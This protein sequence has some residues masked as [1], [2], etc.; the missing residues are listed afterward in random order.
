MIVCSDFYSHPVWLLNGLF[1]E[2]HGQSLYNRNLFA[3]W[4]VG[5]APS[6]VAE[7]GGGFGTLARIIGTRLPEARIDIIEPH[8]H[9]LALAKAAETTNVRYLSALDDSYDIMVA[10]DVFEHVP[11]P[12]QLAVDA[13]AHLK[14]GGNYLIANCFAPVI[15]CH[16]P[17]TFHFRHSWDQA[18][19][20]MGL[21]P[22]E[23]VAYG[24]VFT[25]R[26]HLNLKA[27]RAVERR[28]RA[29][30]PV[31]RYLPGRL[32]RTLAGLLFPA[33]PVTP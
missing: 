17:T 10:T 26:G 8:P 31:S 14:V 11:D 12:L 4:I 33:H 21:E 18:M 13:A 5:Q 16:L 3:D 6:S 7:I 32:V 9:S 23:R 22:R 25:R 29:L 30:W 15:A 2:Q 20:A 27:A 28:S 19:R 1:V 24:R